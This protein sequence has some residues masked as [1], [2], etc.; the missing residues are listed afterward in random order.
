MAVAATPPPA[1]KKHTT[2]GLFRSLR[3]NA[4]KPA[5]DVGGVG[6]SCD[7]PLGHSCDLPW[8]HIVQHCSLQGQIDRPELSDMKSRLNHPQLTNERS[9]TWVQTERAAHEAWGR[10][11]VSSPRAAA[12]M[13][14]LVAEMD[15]SAAVVASHATL[16][17]L[18]GMS[19]STVKRAI[20]DLKAGNWVQAL[21]LGGKGGA[22][23]FVVNS[24]VGWATKRNKMHMAAFTAKVLASGQEQEPD[25][26]DGPPLHRLP[27]LA[28]GEMQL[29]MG[30][31]EDPPSQPAIPGLEPDL[32]NIGS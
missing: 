25:Y 28:P 12:L 4:L 31:G 14:Y 20:A 2:R 18:S 30:N 26:L 8:L 29:P 15:E 1:S 32:P 17:A 23:A 22:L 5:W 21:Q 13:H 10:L 19:T 9:T 16:A 3:G 24:R 6:H 11:T 7:L 27:V